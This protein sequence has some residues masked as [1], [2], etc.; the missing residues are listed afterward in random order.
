MSTALEVKAYLLDIF[1][2]GQFW[3]NQSSEFGDR[4]CTLPVLL[5]TSC[6][7][8]GLKSLYL[9]SAICFDVFLVVAEI[10][11]YTL[12]LGGLFTICL[13]SFWISLCFG[14]SCHFFSFSLWIVF[15][16]A[17]LLFLL[18]IDHVAEIIRRRRGCC[19]GM[20]MHVQETLHLYADLFNDD[21][22]SE[23]FYLNKAVECVA[24]CFSK[25][26]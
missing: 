19:A 13:F 3:K 16:F 2:L 11:G 25:G 7:G 20:K 9:L 1:W 12:F 10:A 15:L 17:E 23:L 24:P 22:S 26:R 21:I 18:L 14:S 8:V 6:T 5:C 4:S